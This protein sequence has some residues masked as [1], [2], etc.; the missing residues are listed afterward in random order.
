M[1]YRDEVLGLFG[2]ILFGLIVIAILVFVLSQMD[3][4]QDKEV[5]REELYRFAFLPLRAPRLPSRAS[6]S[7]AKPKGEDQ[8]R[9]AVSQPPTTKAT[10]PSV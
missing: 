9:L 6:G 7:A 2:A 5:R 8:P 10:G 3:P 1:S 4:F